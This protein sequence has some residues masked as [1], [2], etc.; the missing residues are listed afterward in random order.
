MKP[1]DLPRI[2]EN[3]LTDQEHEREI[4]I[5]PER[6]GT[7]YTVEWTTVEYNWN[8]LDWEPRH[9]SSPASGV[10]G[11]VGTGLRKVLYNSTSFLNERMPSFDVDGE[12]IN[13]FEIDGTYLFKH[14]FEQD[15]IFAQ[16]RPYYNESDYRFEVPANAL[17]EVQALLEDRFF[18]LT[19]VDDVEP[20]CVVKRKYTDHPDVLFKASVVERTQQDYHVF[21]MKDQL[22]VEQAVNNGAIRLADADIDGSVL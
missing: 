18:E 17:T 19:V 12:Q 6:I 21:L 5:R 22:S 13:A 2:V 16:L 14:Y 11:T 10:L 9:R 20:F 7:R 3:L 4:W 8:Q 15:D 1:S